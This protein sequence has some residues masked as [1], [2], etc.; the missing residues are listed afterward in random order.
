M[1]PS[2]DFMSNLFDEIGD[3]VVGFEG[4]FEELLALVTDEEGEG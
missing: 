4:D 3:C 1:E 2:A